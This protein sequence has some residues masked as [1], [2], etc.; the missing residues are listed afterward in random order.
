M[1]FYPNDLHSEP[2]ARVFEI[3]RRL[4]FAMQG[5][6][7]YFFFLVI[8]YI[9]LPFIMKDEKTL[10]WHVHAP[11]DAL[12]DRAEDLNVRMPTVKN[13]IVVHVWYVKISLFSKFTLNSRLCFSLLRM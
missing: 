12:A 7:M 13:D 5:F 6:V 3:V 4:V 8:T 9:T 2:R 11:F 1:F 10:F